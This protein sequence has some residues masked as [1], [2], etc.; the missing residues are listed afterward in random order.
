[1][2]LGSPGRRLLDVNRVRRSPLVKVVPVKKNHSSEAR[3]ALPEILSGVAAIADTANRDPAVIAHLAAATKVA[4]GLLHW[5]LR[6]LFLNTFAYGSVGTEADVAEHLRTGD[7]LS[8]TQASVLHAT[9]NDA[10][11]DI[12]STFR[13]R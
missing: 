4:M 8:P 2:W 10:L 1:M 11:R 7:H 9:L 5:E 12:N 6:D 13:V 3:S